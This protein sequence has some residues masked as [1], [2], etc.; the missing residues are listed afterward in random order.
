[1]IC[2]CK[3]IEELHTEIVHSSLQEKSNAFYYPRINSLSPSPATRPYGTSTVDA[4][5][6]WPATSR[7][8]DVAGESGSRPAYSLCCPEVPI[9]VL[10]FPCCS[11]FS[12]SLLLRVA[13]WRFPVLRVPALRSCATWS[14]KCRDSSVRDFPV[15]RCAFPIGPPCCRIAPLLGAAAWLSVRRFFPGCSLGLWRPSLPVLDCRSLLVVGRL[16]V[17]EAAALGCSCWRI[18][19]VIGL[20][21]GEALTASSSPA[22]LRLLQHYQITP[23]IRY[24]QCLLSPLVSWDCESDPKQMFIYFIALRDLCD[25]IR[26]RDCLYGF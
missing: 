14:R 3:V 15:L 2:W 23:R 17:D 13:V 4:P 26:I 6:I 18:S 5:D 9:T 24:Y 21:S 22:R 12:C 19:I 8:D 10:R 16:L 7:V 1:M 20:W 25:I 11:G